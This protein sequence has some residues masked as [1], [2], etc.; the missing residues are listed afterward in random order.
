MLSGKVQKIE[1]RE[2]ANI[3]LV[4]A[5][6]LIRFDKAV[7]YM[8]DLIP[9]E[10]VNKTLG[11][12]NKELNTKIWRSIGVDNEIQG[13]AVLIEAEVADKAAPNVAE[14]ESGELREVIAEVTITPE[15]TNA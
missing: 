9:T 5:G 8:P 10:T 15:V 11:I 1:P 4:R 7:L 6:N 14:A 12:Q 13:V 3:K 2:G